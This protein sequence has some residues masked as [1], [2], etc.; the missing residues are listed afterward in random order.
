MH[1]L[2]MVLTHNGKESPKPFLD[3]DG[4]PEHHQHLMSC[5][6]SHSQHFRVIS[7]SVNNFLNYFADKKTKQKH[8]RIAISEHYNT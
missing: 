3:P 6:L 4:H 7:F 1:L 5:S 8:T 2:K